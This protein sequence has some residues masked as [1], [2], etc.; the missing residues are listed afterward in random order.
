MTNYL[1]IGIFIIMGVGIVITVI[2]VPD[3]NKADALHRWEQGG[4]VLEKYNNWYGKEVL[5]L[6]NDGKR[7]L[8]ESCN[9]CLIGDKVTLHMYN[10][11]LSWVDLK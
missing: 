6:A 9:K 4:V 2:M 7:Y 10:D 8:D 5:V 3:M 11:F 1:L